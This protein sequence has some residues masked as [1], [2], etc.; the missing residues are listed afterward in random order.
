MTFLTE[1]LAP[2]KSELDNAN[3]RHAWSNKVR[4]LSPLMLCLLD[5]ISA[6]ATTTTKYEAFHRKCRSEILFMICKVL[7]IYNLSVLHSCLCSHCTYL[8]G[9]SVNFAEKTWRHNSCTT[10]GFVSYKPKSPKLLPTSQC[11]CAI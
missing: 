11:P 2:S 1:S 10:T 6:A 3:S 7:I 9:A 8:P 5:F 4:S